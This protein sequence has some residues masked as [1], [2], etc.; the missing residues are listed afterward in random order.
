MSF[1]KVVEQQMQVTGLLSELLFIRDDRLVL[2]N[3][4]SFTREE[5]ETFID[6]LNT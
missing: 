6:E 2:L 1:R 4:V 3:N 5:I